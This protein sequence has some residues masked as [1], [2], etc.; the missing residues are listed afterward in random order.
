MGA[1]YEAEQ[2]QPRRF[3]ALKVIKPGPRGAELLWR[4]E[5]ESRVLGRLQHPGI[6]QIY[7]AGT[8]DAGIGPQHFFAME[9]IHGQSLR[10]YVEDQ[11]PSL[12]Q[13]LDLM[14]RICDAVHHAHQRGVIHRDLKP[15]N[16][17]V[18]G[19]RQ[20]KILDFGVARATDSDAQTTRR[21]DLGQ[22]V[23]TLAYMSPEQVLGDPLELDSRSDVYALGV[24]LYELLAGRLPYEI[25]HKLHEAVQTIREEDPARLSSVSRAYRGDLETIVAKALEKDKARRYASAAE[26]ATDIK[27]YLQD[28]PIVARPASTVYQLQKFARRHKALVAGMA[29][30]FVVLAGGIVAS[31]WQAARAT[32]AQQAALRERD[33]AAAAE[34][35]ATQERDRALSAEHAAAAAQAQSLQERNRAVSEKVRADT[36]SAT[37]KTVNDFLQNDLLAQAGASAQ[38]SPG[39]KPDPDLKVRTALDRAAARIGGRFNRQ[40]L[41]EASIRETIGNTYADLGLLPEAQLQLE[42]A[43]DLRRHALGEQHPDAL[44]TMNKVALLLLRQGKYAQAEPLFT[45]ILRVQP[46][47]GGRENRDTLDTMNNLAVLYQ[48]EG[49]YAQAEALFIKVL[50]AGRRV[51]STDDPNMLDTMNNLALLYLYQGKYSEA[52]PLFTRVLEITRRQRGEEHPDTLVSMNNLALLYLYQGRYSQAEPLFVRTLDLRRRVIGDEHPNTLRSANNLALLYL[53]QGKYAQA[54]ALFNRIL[55]VH[56]RVLGEEHPDTLICS[57][58]L[59]LLYF[60]RGQYAQ[61][62]ALYTKVLHARSRKLGDEHPSTANASALLGQVQLQQGNYSAAETLLR[63]ALNVQERKRPDTWERFNSQSLL[64]ATLMAQ[65]KYGEAEPLL[66]SGYAGLVQ[67][68]STIPSIYP[69]AIQQAGERLVQLYEQWGRSEKASDWRN[70]IQA[71]AAAG[72]PKL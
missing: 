19:T 59:A 70:K 20:P 55:P 25:S 17:L 11:K 26:L 18:D 38:A 62:E 5:Q 9:F 71:G 39:T 47:V 63:D 58:N 10:Q 52:E 72:V 44:L 2:E 66:L 31:S 69:S 37:A 14:I 29:A 61:A 6:A 48:H 23:G 51:M 42:R 8:A 21:T 67:R 56:A 4:F 22:L 12:Q 16:I 60:R 41:V 30:V 28:E 15:N 57:S 1:V 50:E 49:K 46:H 64:G 54:E 24:I 40:P 65:E 43:L 34:Q 27:R 32:R 45:R 35:N 13:R 36:Q 33:R 68:K 3:V 53:S 7:E